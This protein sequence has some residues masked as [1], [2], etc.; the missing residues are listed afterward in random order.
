MLSGG[1][2]FLYNIEVWTHTGASWSLKT[3]KNLSNSK[4]E[5]QWSHGHPE[6]EMQCLISNILNQW[7]NQLPL[8]LWKMTLN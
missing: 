3:L 8:S 1:C 7:I 5:K 2:T 4:L 6:T